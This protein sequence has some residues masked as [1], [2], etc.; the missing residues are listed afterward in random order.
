M[1][2]KKSN[3]FYFIVDGQKK[4]PFY[5]CPCI[6][7][8]LSLDFDYVKHFKLM[9]TESDKLSAK[10]KTR[11]KLHKQIIKDLLAGKTASNNPSCKFLISGERDIHAYKQ[12]DNKHSILLNFDLVA[13]LIPEKK[14]NEQILDH[15]RKTGDNYDELIKFNDACTEEQ[16]YIFLLIFY[17]SALL[18]LDIIMPGMFYIEPFEL[19]LSL[20]NLKLGYNDLEIYLLEVDDNYMKNIE[21]KRPEMSYQSF[22]Y[23]SY[24]SIFEIIVSDNNMLI[25]RKPKIYK[26]MLSEYLQDK[27]VQEVSI[28]VVENELKKFGG[29][30]RKYKRKITRIKLK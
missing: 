9:L 6:A 21:Q 26:A 17:H 24:R 18:K 10:F 19:A 14:E 23:K 2:N 5:S 11:A 12:L 27:A 7:K 22:M 1:S 4:G 3:E 15:A 20:F 25:T 16:A 8:E 29:G 28:E 30:T 13:K